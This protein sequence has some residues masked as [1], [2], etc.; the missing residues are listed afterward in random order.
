MGGS[1]KNIKAEYFTDKCKDIAIEYYLLKFWTLAKIATH[2]DISIDTVRDRFKKWGIKTRKRHVG[3]VDFDR[4]L[5]E[6]IMLEASDPDIEHVAEK[7]NCPIYAVRMV[8][9]K[10][11]VNTNFIIKREK[12]KNILSL[13]DAEITF[14]RLKGDNILEIARHYKL[15]KTV[16]YDF[17]KERGIDTRNNKFDTYR[18]KM[19]ELKPKIIEMYFDE[20]IPIDEI[21][22]SLGLHR[23]SISKYF[24]RWKIKARPLLTG[25]ISR[26][27]KIF[28]K[29]F[30]EKYS[31]N[32]INQYQI[33]NRYYDFYLPDYNLLIEV[34]GDFWHFNPKLYK[35]PNKYQIAGMERDVIKAKLA[36]DSLKGLEFIWEDDIKNNKN[37]VIEIL[38][39]Y[40][41]NYGN[42]N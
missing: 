15:P 10:N 29:D 40:I 8:F 18:K 7:L 33:T 1:L 28:Q 2:F 41:K 31:I 24:K 11:G 27:E 26:V 3:A 12:Y 35:F 13:N 25:T 23:G 19:E 38:S 39:K 4:T 6:K 32:F 42:Q 5:E 14:R 16:L 34:Q 20:K 36:E 9:K 30:L 17:F 37:K 22:D 21:S